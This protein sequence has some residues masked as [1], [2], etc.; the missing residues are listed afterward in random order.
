MVC[1]LVFII[2]VSFF[3]YNYGLKARMASL[4]SKLGIEN[5]CGND[6]TNIL[7]VI[8]ID[9]AKVDFLIDQFRSYSIKVLK[10]ALDNHE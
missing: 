6:I 2:I 8:P 1:F 9:Y 10:Q 5:H 3:Y 7:N 4:G